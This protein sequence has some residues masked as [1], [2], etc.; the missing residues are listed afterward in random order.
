MGGSRERAKFHPCLPECHGP[1]YLSHSLVD[2]RYDAQFADW[3]V[4]AVAY[5]Y[6]HLFQHIAT[7]SAIQGSLDSLFE[8]MSRGQG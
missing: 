8:T 5:L 6:D 3:V 7:T 4:R 1:L 2:V